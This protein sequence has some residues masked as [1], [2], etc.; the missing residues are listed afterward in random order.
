MNIIIL[1]ISSNSRVYYIV[2]FEKKKKNLEDRFESESFSCGKHR[3]HIFF[4]SFAVLHQRGLGGECI[5]FNRVLY[6]FKE[7]KMFSLAWKITKPTVFQILVFMRT[8]VDESDVL[9]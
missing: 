7:K 9:R 1:K 5:E 3:G 2:L 6:K 8:V 4:L